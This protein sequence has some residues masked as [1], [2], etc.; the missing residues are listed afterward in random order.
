MFDL[1]TV[2]YQAKEFFDGSDATEMAPGF[3]SVNLLEQAGLDPENLADLS[4]VHTGGILSQVGV[5]VGSEGGGSIRET[6]SSGLEDRS[7][8]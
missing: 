3:D 2:L 1:S 6:I 8:Q 4:S 5:D 7:L